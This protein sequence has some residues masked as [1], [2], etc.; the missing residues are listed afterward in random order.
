MKTPSTAAIIFGV[1]LL[2]LKA[3]WHYLFVYDANTYHPCDDN[4]TQG[5]L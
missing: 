1:V 4:D 5:E 2:L 3:A